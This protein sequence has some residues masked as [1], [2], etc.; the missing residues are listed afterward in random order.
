M[1]LFFSGEK[2]I[3]QISDDK[4]QALQ[5]VSASLSC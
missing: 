5:I 2:M 1:T 4:G 3:V